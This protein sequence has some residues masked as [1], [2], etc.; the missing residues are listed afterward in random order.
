MDFK[1]N[2]KKYL[3]LLIVILSIS[4]LSL[5][6]YKNNEIK[7]NNL[8]KQDELSN[9]Y[10]EIEKIK[11][12]DIVI[13]W[14]NLEEIRRLNSFYTDKP[15]LNYYIFE[16]VKNKDDSYCNSIK[17]EERNNFCKNLIKDWVLNKKYLQEYTYIDYWWEDYVNLIE[18]IFNWNKDCSYIKKEKIVYMDC[19]KFNDKNFDPEKF[20]YW[21]EKLLK[22]WSFYLIQKYFEVYIKEL[23][24]PRDSTWIINWFIDEHMKKK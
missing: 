8:N 22:W 24:L 11:N 10:K 14:N 21:Y 17:D 12:I 19:K 5:F 23:W 9:V 15:Y 6:Y 1:K 13:N 16:T 18:N 2:N 20:Y 4:V 3:I 7:K